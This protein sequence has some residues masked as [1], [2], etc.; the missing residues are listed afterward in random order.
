MGR[1]ALERPVD[2][3][4]GRAV[5]QRDHLDAAGVS[6]RVAEVVELLDGRVLEADD[7]HRAAAGHHKDRAEGMGAVEGRTEVVAP[8]LLIAVG[9]VQ[10][11]GGAVVDILAACMGDVADLAVLIPPPHLEGLIHVAV[12][13]GVGV[14]QPG[15]LDRLDQLDRLRHGLARQ[16]LA[17]DVPARVQGADGEARMLG[18]VVGEDDG[19]E[20][21]GEEVVEVREAGDLLP[22]LR[23]LLLGLPEQRLVAVADGG[24][25]RLGVVQQRVHH[26][27]AARAA[28]HADSQLFLHDFFSFRLTERRPGR[29]MDREAPVPTGQQTRVY[30]FRGFLF[31]YRVANFLRRIL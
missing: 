18:G 13:L 22:E 1:L 20:V 25:L 17:H 5:V 15:S 14:D 11:A 8:V 26:G 24:Q 6:A 10:P 31:M 7:L 9:D 12:V 4:H 21:V 29:K 23:G 30:H 16:H 28:K 3:L 27:G 19:V 2:A